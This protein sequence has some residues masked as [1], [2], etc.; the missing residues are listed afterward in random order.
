MHLG[1]L[2]AKRSND[3]N[4]SQRDERDPIAQFIN[5]NESA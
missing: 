1:S 4:K 3:G 2:R 5:M